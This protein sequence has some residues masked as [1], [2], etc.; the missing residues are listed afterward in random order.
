MVQFAYVLLF[1]LMLTVLLSGQ[2]TTTQPKPVATTRAAKDLQGKDH[3]NKELE[4]KAKKLLEAAEEVRHDVEL[5]AGQKFRKEVES[6]VH[7][8]KELAE[9]L[10]KKIFEEELAGG[11][12]ER[13][14]FLLRQI[15]LI[16]KD[17]DLAKEFLDM[18]VSQVGGFYDP[19]RGKFFMMLKS[20]KMGEMANRT[21]MAHELT[22]ALDDQLYDLERFS[23]NKDMSEDEG[24]ATGSVIEGSA[25]SLMIRWTLVNM[26][27]FDRKEMM[28]SQ[29]EETDK[30]M[31]LFD[32]PEYFQTIVAKYYIG[33]NFL[34]KGEGMRSLMQAGKT[35]LRSNIERCFKQMPR[36]SEQILHPY[37]YWDKEALD[38]PVMLVDEKAFEEAQGLQVIGHDTLGELL[39]GILGKPKRSNKDKKFLEVRIQLMTQ[40]KYWIHKSGSGWGGDRVFIVGPDKKKPTGLV[41][42]IWWDKKKDVA[43]FLAAYKKVGG[44]GLDYGVTSEGK[45]CVLTYGSL[46]GQQDKILAGALA[47]PVQKGKTP[48]QVED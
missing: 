41:W 31:K 16:P 44:K 8:E 30:S 36:S 15:G 28:E 5:L 43:E 25:T 6:Q 18:L 4:A 2:E 45:L 27:K 38:L 11:R 37:K 48:F 32:Y 1:P 24:F 22:H 23:S 7:N 33:L 46:K 14:Q 10:K 19:E 21:V 39:C 17:M 12:L 9:F 29:K 20:A 40:P 34:T 3:Q 26:N 35:G 42:L 13:S 47:A